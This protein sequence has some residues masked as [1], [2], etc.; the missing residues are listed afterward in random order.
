LLYFENT[1]CQSCR[2]PLGYIPD[3]ASLSALE[4]D[5]GT[6]R[7]LAA[8]GRF[9]SC[10]NARHD[11]CNWLVPTA[12]GE[13]FCTACRHNATIPPLDNPANVAAWRKLETAKHRL[14]YGLLQLRLPLAARADDPEHGLAFDFLAD[15]PQVSGPRV[16]TGHDNGLITIALVEADDA[17]RE[18]RRIAMREPYRTLLGHFRHEVG[19]HYWD[20]LVRDRNRLAA[21]RTLFGDERQDYGDALQRHYA[22][23]APVQWQDSFVSAYA[24]SHP[25]EDF[26]ETWAHYLHIVDTLEMA[27]AFGIRVDPRVAEE[28]SLKA[29]ISFDAYRAQHVQQLVDAWLPLTVALNSLNRAMGQPDLYPFILSP[30]VVQKL[31]FVHAIIRGDQI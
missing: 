29:E 10:E 28:P 17:E 30:M 25:W 7:A 3:M 12:S 27:A 21:F 18:K 14:I 9:R 26:A 16:V 2:H 13:P 6:W 15:P 11:V 1:H 5:G 4:P 23:P 19:H 31:S 22:E 8:P 20:L 24:A